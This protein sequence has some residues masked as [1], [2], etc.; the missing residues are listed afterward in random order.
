MDVTPRPEKSVW[1]PPANVVVPPVS[2]NQL[3]PVLKYC[4]AEKVRLPLRPLVT[5]KALVSVPE[6]FSEAPSATFRA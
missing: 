3:V 2:V 4:R 1:S 6:T 5:L